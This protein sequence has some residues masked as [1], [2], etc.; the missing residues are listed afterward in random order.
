MNAPEFDYIANLLK[1]RSG[2][3][4]GKDKSYLLETRL[5]PIAARAKVASVE[6][7]IRGLRQGRHAEFIAEITSAMTTNESSFFRDGRPFETFR[8]DI[9]P[10]L[11]ER[12]DKS[13]TIRIWC[14]AASTGQ[15]PYTL[16]MLL[17]EEKALFGSHRIEIIGTDIAP[18]VLARA[19][20]GIYSH[21]EVQRGLPARLLVKYF[22]KVDDQWQIKPELRQMVQYREFNL[23]NDLK[24]LGRFDIIFCR[25]V[26]I[27]FDQ[28]TKANVLSA[29]NGIIADDG[30]LFL[31]G[32]ETVLGISDKFK[33]VAG[34]RGVY[35]PVFT[36][37]APRMAI[38]T[39]PVPN[40]VTALPRPAPKTTP[41]APNST[42]WRAAA[43][44]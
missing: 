37:P 1:Q 20:E 11:L 3:A 8:T 33:L 27:Y 26:L 15:E 13:K 21:F 23:L 30:V 36:A 12:R 40:L 18:E 42:L 10:R 2:L 4:L 44:Q 24:P 19:R 43:G 22:D 16:A 38:P 7:L 25:N 6:E 17:K 34:Q 35:S 9:L 31:G 14:A 28:P 39:S 29:M 5:S 32:A 41:T